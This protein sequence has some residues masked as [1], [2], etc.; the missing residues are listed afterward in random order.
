MNYNSLV[1][2]NFKIGLS[3]DINIACCIHTLIMFC[4]SFVEYFVIEGKYY[5]ADH[6]MNFLT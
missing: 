5:D 6:I 3:K 1:R 4:Y 2:S